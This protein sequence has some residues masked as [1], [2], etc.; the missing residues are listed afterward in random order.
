MQAR[1]PNNCLIGH[2]H[3]DAN[4]LKVRKI[5]SGFF[6]LKLI[7]AIVSFIHW[8]Y[9]H[10][11][12]TCLSDDC[13]RTNLRTFKKERSLHLK[14]KKPFQHHSLEII[15]WTSNL[16]QVE[17]TVTHTDHKKRKL[18]LSSLQ[19]SQHLTQSHTIFNEPSFPSRVPEDI[20]GW[21]SECPRTLSEYSE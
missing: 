9:K 1:N 18:L 5:L 20:I 12:N 14:G 19:L 13:P 4:W 15:R 17:F 16:T 10:K 8:E 3:D 11:R 6:C 7:R 21:P 2:L